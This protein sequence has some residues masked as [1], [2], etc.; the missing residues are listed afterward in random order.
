MEQEGLDIRTSDEWDTIW[1]LNMIHKLKTPRKY[2]NIKDTWTMDI[3]F[4]TIV[5]YYPCSIHQPQ[6]LKQ[7][8]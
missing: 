4:I 1:I 3:P 6:N 8:E 7:R 2:F 5:F